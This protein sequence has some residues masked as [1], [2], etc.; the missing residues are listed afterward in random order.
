MDYNEYYRKSGVAKAVKRQNMIRIAAAIFSILVLSV[1]IAVAVPRYAK[2]ETDTNPAFWV[3]LIVVSL[4][5]IVVFKPLKVFDKTWGGTIHRIKEDEDVSM[6]YS[7]SAGGTRKLEFTVIQE[8]GD[9]SVIVY[10][11]KAADIAD[12]YY[13]EGDRVIHFAGTEFLHNLDS[14]VEEKLCLFCGH[15]TLDNRC[16]RCKKPILTVCEKG[17]D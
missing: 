16:P 1:G 4:L 12:H 2:L 7:N 17:E 5:P 3:F 15:T 9:V 14:T 11:N 6:T 10:K 8:S 13:K